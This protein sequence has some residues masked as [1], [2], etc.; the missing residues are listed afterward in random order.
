VFMR[1]RRPGEPP[2]AG[3]ALDCSEAGRGLLASARG[4]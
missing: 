4:G 3:P 2:P 1:D